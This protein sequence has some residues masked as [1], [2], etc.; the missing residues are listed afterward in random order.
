LWAALDE[1]GQIAAQWDGLDAAPQSWRPGDLV[2]QWHR[3][4][5]PTAAPV[6]L[7]AGVY[8]GQTGERLADAAGTDV[9]VLTCVNPSTSAGQAVRSET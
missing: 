9:L 6:C 8:D 2:W 4:A 7:Q 3:F 5:L 1:T